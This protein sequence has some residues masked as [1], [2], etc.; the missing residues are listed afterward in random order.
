MQEKYQIGTTGDAAFM[1]ILAFLVAT[2]IAMGISAFSAR[3][4]E[5]VY[6]DFLIGKVGAPLSLA[7]L[8]SAFLGA[9]AGE[10]SWSS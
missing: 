3:N 7:V 2:V 4:P 1:K 10:D 6:M 5:V 8:V 9:M